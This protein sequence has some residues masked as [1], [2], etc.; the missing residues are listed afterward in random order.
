MR[1]KKKPIKRKKKQQKGCYNCA[2]R[3][4][5]GGGQSVCRCYYPM[6]VIIHGRHSKEYNYCARTLWERRET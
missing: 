4:D 6:V 3:V 1:I 2:H 5:I